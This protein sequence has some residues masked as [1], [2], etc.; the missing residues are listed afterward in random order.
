MNSETTIR[1]FGAILSLYGS[2]AKPIHIMVNGKISIKPPNRN[3]V[4]L[5]YLFITSAVKAAAITGQIVV[6]IG[7]I[8]FETGKTRL[9]ILPPYSSTESTPVNC[10]NIDT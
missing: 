10:W 4:F 5:P 2:T 7:I 6:N 3:N 9:K 1:I 8:L